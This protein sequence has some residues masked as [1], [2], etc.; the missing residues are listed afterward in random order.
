MHPDDAVDCREFDESAWLLISGE[1][2]DSARN[3]WQRHLAGCGRCASLLAERRRVLDIYDG[4]VSVSARALDFSR[5]PAPARL[6]P[7]WRQ[8][9]VAVA[10]GL[11]LLI[12]GALTGRV[13]S[14][15]AGDEAAL[16]DVER[17]LTDLEVQLAVA[18]MNPPTAAERLQATAAG[19]V[20]VERDPRI[21]DSLL[22][23]LE[24]DPSPNVR[25]A[26]VTALY[27][28]ES[29]TRVE[30]RYETLLAAQRLPML[31]IAL[32]E[33]AADRRLTHALSVLKRL[34][35]APGEE[36]VR[37][38]AQWAIGVLNAGA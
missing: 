4:L 28:I 27:E 7:P 6:Q 20:L 30:Q 11:L 2:D 25:M 34:A 16:H 38:R 12:A 22:D 13:M 29:I 1:L 15:S 21:I 31:R 35:A 37:E 5:G 33:L 23:A 8:P 9:S 17:R 24:T 36:A 10:A 14:R 18:R 19:A 32:I 3:A 26:V